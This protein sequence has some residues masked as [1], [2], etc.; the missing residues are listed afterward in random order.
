MTRVDPKVLAGDFLP[1]F[2]SCR[3]FSL[4]IIVVADHRVAHFWLRQPTSFS[5][6]GLTTTATA[7]A[8][9]I[10]CPTA[11]RSAMYHISSRTGRDEWSIRYKEA[12]QEGDI[13]RFDLSL[14]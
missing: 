2:L 11:I 10:S 12:V 7:H 13:V 4:F 8:D 14:S 5:A 3:L 9:G 6:P 1:G